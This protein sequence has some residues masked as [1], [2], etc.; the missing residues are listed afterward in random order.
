M[1][2]GA[3]VNIG[4]SDENE[5]STPLR[6]AANSNYRDICEYLLANGAVPDFDWE[7]VMGSSPTISWDGES[8]HEVLLIKKLNESRTRLL[9]RV[10]EFTCA[11]CDDEAPREFIA[12]P[13]E[14]VFHSVC[15]KKWAHEKGVEASCPMC[16]APIVA[17]SD[18]PESQT[19]EVVSPIA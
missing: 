12:L 7:D 5:L 4:G 14:H 17:K 13:C 2:H 8:S 10:K 6:E 1:E 19:T 18:D 15:L 9:R 3:N 11:I 16:R